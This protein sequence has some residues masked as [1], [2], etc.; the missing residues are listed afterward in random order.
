ME[1]VIAKILAFPWFV[2]ILSLLFAISMLGFWLRIR[3]DERQRKDRDEQS[4]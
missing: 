2:A 1:H 4:S 3:H